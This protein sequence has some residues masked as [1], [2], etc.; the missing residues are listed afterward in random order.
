[1]MIGAKMQN[2]AIL[3]PNFNGEKFIIETIRLL[4]N[5]FQNIDIIVV[6]DASSDSSVALLKQ[7][8]IN[9]VQRA[10]NGGFAATVNSGLHYLQSQNIEFA[11]V[12]NSD[13]VPSVE[14]CTNISKSF[15]NFFDDSRVGVIGFLERSEF[16]PINRE[17]SEISGFL[18]WIKIGVI[19]EVGYFDERFYMYGEETDFFRRVI[20]NAYKIVQSGVEVSHA[21][22]KSGKS[23]ILNSWY[24]MRNCLFLEI[25]N[26]RIK[27]ATKK[28]LALLLIMFGLLGNKED[29]STRRVRRPG[30]IV[31]PVMLLGAI[32]WNIYQLLNELTKREKQ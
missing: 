23:K 11:L 27:A 6:D 12:C 17:P 22:E 14:E 1:M 32:L 18:F 7:N 16:K 21:A 9:V 5:G 28:S 8:G 3:I 20:A 10:T 24:A 13:L 31:G 25:K 19:E 29:P 26:N 4:T 2:A 15:E 30:F